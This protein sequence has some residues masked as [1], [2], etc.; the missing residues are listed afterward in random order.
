MEENQ[1]NTN[2]KAPQTNQEKIQIQLP[3][4]TGVLVMGI[5]SIVCFCCL[6]AGIAG[7]ILGILAIVYGNKAIEL[8]NRHPEKYTLSSYKNTKAGR[9]CGIIGVSIGGVYVIG[10]LIW[11]SMIGW[12]IGTV[13]TTMPWNMF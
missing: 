2:Q 1:G 6:A 12:A 9:V 8:Y 4:S 3:N 7:I 10:L 5:I 11:L 13:F